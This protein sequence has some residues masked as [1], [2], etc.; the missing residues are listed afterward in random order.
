MRVAI[1]G[2]GVTGGF[3][4]GLS[5][6][7]AALKSGDVAAD[8]FT[9]PTGT[10]PVEIPAFLAQT[11]RLDEFVPKRA[12]RRIDRYSRLALLG[13]CLAL[14]DGGALGGDLSRTGVVIASGYGATSTTFAFL[15]TIIAD[16]DTLASPTHFA[17]SVHNAAAANITMMLGIKGPCL[18]VSQFD[19]S[20][21][22]ALVSAR[23]WLAEGRCDQVLFGAVD[24]LSDLVGYLWHRQRLAEPEAEADVP[25]EGAAFFLLGR[26]EEG[27]GYCA[28]DGVSVGSGTPP[29]SE[30]PE[31]A[32]ILL[33]RGGGFGGLTRTLEG[34][35]AHLLRLHAGLYG[36]TPAGAGFDLAIAALMLQ[37]EGGESTNACTVQLPASGGYAVTRLSRFRT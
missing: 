23:Q 27:S 21:P 24:E 25:G 30:L 3:G 19:M 33:N 5:D 18:T 7:R 9:V 12:L 20:V 35:P 6:L 10:G 14:S 36:A 34:V 28:I 2:I 22:S 32:P 31:D 11:G 29:R 26:S 8:T 16:G 15:D 13:S 4:C 1:K 17:S 37:G